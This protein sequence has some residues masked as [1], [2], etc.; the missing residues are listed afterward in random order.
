MRGDRRGRRRRLGFALGEPRDEIRAIYGVPL[1]HEAR[2][3]F[4]LVA[5]RDRWS[6]F[7]ELRL[8][9]DLRPD[10]G[11]A[12]PVR[13][14]G[15]PQ[16]AGVP[17]DRSRRGVL[18]RV[19]HRLAG[20]RRHLSPGD[21]RVGRP[22]PG[23][24]L[25]SRDRAR[26]PA[27]SPT[28]STAS[29]TSR[30]LVKAGD[31][32]AISTGRVRGRAARAARQGRADVALLDRRQGS[33]VRR[34]RAEAARHRVLL[35]SRALD[36]RAA[37]ER[38]RHRARRR[39]G[40]VRSPTLNPVIAGRPAAGAVRGVRASSSRPRCTRCGARTCSTSRSSRATSRSVAARGAPGARRGAR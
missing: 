8:D 27:C 3:L 16:P 7:D 22:A 40:A 23:A 18:R 21:L 26:S 25:R 12:Q 10:V 2:R 28:R 29:C 17:R 13:A 4:E 14:D 11:D 6:T 19:R 24:P 38:R 5:G 35:L 20:Q 1:P 15:A 31:G 39:A 36:L 32:R 37:Q 30:A 9:S 33:R 34:A